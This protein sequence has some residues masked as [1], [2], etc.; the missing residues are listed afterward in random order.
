MALAWHLSKAEH[1]ANR[2]AKIH[3]ANRSTPRLDHPGGRMVEQEQLA[4]FVFQTVVSARPDA[5]E[6]VD[7]ALAVAGAAARAVALVL[8]AG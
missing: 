8:R 4:S 3:V 6:V 2:P 1:G 7:L 5:L